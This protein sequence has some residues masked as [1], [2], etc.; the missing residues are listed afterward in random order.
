VKSKLSKAIFDI[1]GIGGYVVA[2]GS[3]HPNGNMYFIEKNIPMLNAPNWVLDLAHT[4]S[5]VR[6]F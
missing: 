2:P 1:K 3:I 6:C 5:F 4:T